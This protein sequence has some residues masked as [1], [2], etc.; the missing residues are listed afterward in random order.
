MKIR[1]K[2]NQLIGC[3]Q[4]LIELGQPTNVSP[5]ETHVASMGVALG[6]RMRVMLAMRRDPANGI[7]L[8]RQRAKGRK[9]ILQRF[10]QAQPPMRQ[11]PMVAQRDAE[12]AGEVQDNGRDDRPTPMKR[13][14]QK[15]R[16][17]AYVNA[18][19]AN[20]VRPGAK[21]ATQ[22][23][24]GNLVAMRSSPGNRPACRHGVGTELPLR[25]RT[26]CR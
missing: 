6:V 7:A 2:P 1:R 11:G 25:R 20:A 19:Q 13:A 22:R 26:G 23:L 15:R 10:T 9:R 21:T 5:A 3:R 12:P 8:Q 16:Q 24:N 14:R 4:R 18:Q 17:R